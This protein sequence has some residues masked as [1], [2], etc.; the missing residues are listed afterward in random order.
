MEEGALY[1]GQCDDAQ[2]PNDAGRLTAQG[3]E[4]WQS[5]RSKALLADSA[6]SDD[7]LGASSAI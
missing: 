6:E 7:L 5:T 3:L 4:I 1:E 2:G